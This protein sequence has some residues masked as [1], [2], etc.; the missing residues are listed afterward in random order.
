MA[1]LI[2]SLSSGDNSV[3]IIGA[4]FN[5]LINLPRP[6]FFRKIISGDKPT[7][8]NPLWIL[9]NDFLSQ[10]DF[11]DRAGLDFSEILSGMNEESTPKKV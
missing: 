8:I 7:V 3:I 1:L 2:N 9:D 6:N 10:T 4:L 5:R 11:V